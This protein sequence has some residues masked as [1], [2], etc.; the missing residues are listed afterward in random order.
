MIRRPYEDGWLL[1]RQTDH[2]R[3]SADL[4]RAWQPAL[5]EPTTF[6]IEHHDD[7]WDAWEERPETGAGVPLNFTELDAASHVAIWERGI[8]RLKDPY[9]KLLVS[10][11]AC[12]L[13]S[14]KPGTEDFFAL[15][16]QNQRAW[17]SEI[18]V[19]TLETLH[20]DF[21]LLQLFDWLSLLLAW[22]D[23]PVDDVAG[24]TIRPTLRGALF[25]PFPFGDRPITVSTTGRW[26]RMDHYETADLQAALAEAPTVH[27]TWELSAKA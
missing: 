25:D 22:K 2:A 26:I 6:L 4:A 15:Q 9:H 24:M 5:P 14:H 20:T 18:P 19:S 16:A 7:G 17:A 1:I 21:T 27:L 8:T 11:H 3:L 12:H 23:E 10:R 13:M